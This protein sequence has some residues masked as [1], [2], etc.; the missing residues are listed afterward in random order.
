MQKAQK[1]QW[2]QDDPKRSMLG[3]NCETSWATLGLNCE[4]PILLATAHEAGIVSGQCFQ[5]NPHP[6]DLLHTDTDRVVQLTRQ[7]LLQLSLDLAVV[8]VHTASCTIGF[9]G[10]K[11]R[12]R[13]TAAINSSSRSTIPSTSSQSHPQVQYIQLR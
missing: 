1:K 7:G 4:P 6:Q 11:S 9:S 3:L 10:C 2:I 12:T 13:T 8:L 5:S